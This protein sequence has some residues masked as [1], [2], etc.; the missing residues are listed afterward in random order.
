VRH[1]RIVQEEREILKEAAAGLL[2]EAEP[3]RS[4][5][6]AAQKAEHTSLEPWEGILFRR[7]SFL[8]ITRGYIS[9]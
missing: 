5:F 7:T 1:S 6:I 9:D 3:M 4:T 2:R 8:R